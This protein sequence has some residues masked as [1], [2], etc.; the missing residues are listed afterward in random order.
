MSKFEAQIEE[1]ERVI[2]KE[3]EGIW[4]WER[5]SYYNKKFNSG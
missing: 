3:K 5:G 4:K 2:P 1:R